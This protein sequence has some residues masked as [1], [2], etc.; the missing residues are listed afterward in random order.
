MTSK[1]RKKS[2]LSKV[3]FRSDYCIQYF[4]GGKSQRFLFNLLDTKEMK[5]PIEMQ[6][7]PIF[8]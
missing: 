3:G 2:E 1:K 4:G 8:T 5:Q 7:V 6:T